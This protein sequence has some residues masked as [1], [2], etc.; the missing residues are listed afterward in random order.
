MVVPTFGSVRNFVLELAPLA[1][2]VTQFKVI[3][4]FNGIGVSVKDCAVAADDGGNNQHGVGVLVLGV[5]RVES[6]GN[7]GG[8]HGG[9]PFRLVMYIL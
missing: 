6:V 4:R 3:L 7:G 5:A 9:C 2:E 8:H 1:P